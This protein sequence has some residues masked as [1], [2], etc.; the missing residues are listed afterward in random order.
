MDAV[1]RGLDRFGATLWLEKDDLHGR[2]LQVGDGFEFDI[3][4]PE[5]DGFEPR[6][7]N[8]IGSVIRVSESRP[9]KLGVVIRFHSLHFRGVGAGAAEGT[10]A[11]S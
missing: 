1:V 9:D 3:R 4:L 8:A 5:N 10:A 2:T 6:T 7:L 11:N